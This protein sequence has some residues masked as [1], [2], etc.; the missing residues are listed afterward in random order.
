MS[1]PDSIED[2]SIFLQIFTRSYI[3]QNLVMH[4]SKNH[5]F[6]G[7]YKK[8]KLRVGVVVYTLPEALIWRE[9]QFFDIC[10]IVL[11]RFCQKS[12]NCSFIVQ[13]FNIFNKNLY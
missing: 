2:F 3:L 9:L 8:F 1:K 11:H 12:G 7:Y 5:R 10:Q 13:E 6:N 4:D